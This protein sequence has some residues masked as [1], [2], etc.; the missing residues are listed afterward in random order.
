M[1]VQVQGAPDVPGPSWYQQAMADPDRPLCSHCGK[2]PVLVMK[3]MLCANC[4]ARL[5]RRGTLERKRLPKGSTTL[6]R[7]EFYTVRSEEPDGCWLWRGATTSQ[8]P[9]KD[10]GIVWTGTKH[11][12]AHRFAYEHFVGPIPD[13]LT[14]DH[15]CET[16]RCVRPDHLEPVT[17]AVNIQRGGQWPHD[18]DIPRADRVN[19]ELTR[20]NCPRCDTPYTTDK[21]GKRYCQPCANAHMREWTRRTGRTTGKAAGFRNREK[22]HCDNRHEFTPD[23]TY[24]APDGSRN[25]RTCKNERRRVPNPPANARICQPGCT[26]GRH[27]RKSPHP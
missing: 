23:N 12:L 6:E 11:V 16:P 7:W 22:T 8:E 10:Y 9:G 5:R 25:C 19:L 26:C 3:T 15:T 21:N 2:K 4:T 1:S 17:N 18:P 20:P 13:G 24:I 27:R 14:I